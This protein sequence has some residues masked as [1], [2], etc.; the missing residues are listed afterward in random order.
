MGRVDLRCRC[1]FMF[2][3]NDAERA[4]AP[5]CPSCLSV[6]PLDGPAPGEAPRPAVKVLTTAGA[7]NPD[8]MKMIVA[9]SAGGGLLVVGLVVTFLLL[10][11]GGDDADPDLKAGR[12]PPPRPEPVAVRPP[13]SAA[14]PVPRPAPRPEA[15]APSAPRPA[16]QPPPSSVPAQP[17]TPR[18]AAVAGPPP[19]PAELLAK[20]R[21][22][23]QELKP[24]HLNLAL[25]GAERQRLERLLKDGKGE[26][27][28]VEFLTKL[29]A[30]PKLK[31]VLEEQQA[32]RETARKLE[33]EA[34]ESLPVDKVVMKDGRILQGKVVS[35]T[36]ET[37]GLERKY[38][39]GVGGVLPLKKDDI[40][41]L[42]KG[43]GVGGEF[44][45]RWQAVAA[46]TSPTDL[47]PL[48]AWC[49]ENALPLQAS[50]VAHRLLLVD[51]GL[52]EARQEAGLPSDPI[53]RLL[54]AEKEG[55]FILH[56]GRRWVPSE[57]RD[58]L[59]RD[60]FELMNGSWVSKKDRLISVPGLFRYDRQ[61]DKPVQ[62]HGNG[63]QPV[64]DIEYVF[65]VVQ[66]V[67]AGGF[68]EKVDTKFVRRFWAPPMEVAVSPGLAAN[69][70]PVP[71]IANVNFRYQHDKVL[72]VPG[73]PL[74]GEVSIVVPVNEPI[75]EAWV[76]TAAEVR[77][78]GSITVHYVGDNQQRTQIYLCS[79]KESR[80]HKLPEAV[81]GKTQVE[82]VAVIASTA[83]YKAKLERRRLSNPRRDERTGS[84]IPGVE[85]IHYRQTPEHQAVLF[86]SNS[87]TLEVFRLKVSVAEPAP[88]L[89]K[90]FENAPRELLKQN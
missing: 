15:S 23:I 53:Q 11:G 77:G 89:D 45:T 14:P 43:R 71:S 40:K 65:G 69:T 27:A 25:D 90:L 61:D 12:R 55:G 4:K 49:K 68:V 64:N 38:S 48:L 2:F 50:L 34:L 86:P 75:L 83:V 5:K 42:L 16:V 72:P 88:A 56:Q 37:V 35:E 74:R 21:S 79:P 60:G 6:V 78:T 81:R 82:L 28:D 1:G 85:V 36:P 80:T 10:S 70:A 41:D 44:Q 26:P 22:E 73:A 62:I 67:S 59:L 32:L 54:L 66:D 58:K 29:L 63:C 33:T 20:V 47:A 18:P 24:F 7:S 31:A 46:S 51:P 76:T 39:G 9:L 13:A 17:T 52:P 84:I 3:V 30:G 87:N 8:R 19:L 57:L